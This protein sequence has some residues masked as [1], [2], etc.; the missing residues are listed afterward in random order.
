MIHTDTLIIGGGFSGAKVAQ[1]LAAAGINTLMLDRKDYFEVTYATLRNVTA[2]ELLPKSPRKRY[3]DFLAGKFIHSGVSEMNQHQ[4]ILENG[5]TITFRQAIIATGSRYETMPMVKSNNSL[6][7]EMRNQEQI[8]TRQDIQAAKDILILGG[9]VV[10]VEL[11]GEIAAAFPEK[12]VTLAHSQS[13][14]LD[15]FKPK[16]QKLAFKQL[17]ALGVKI[18]TNRLYRAEGDRY[19]DANTGHTITADLV[20]SAIGTQPNSEFLKPHLSAALNKQ[21]YVKVDAYFQVEGYDNLYSLGDIANT[22]SPKLG[23]VAGMQADLLVKN[24]LATKAGKKA[25]P[26]KP[27]TKM[28]ALVPTGPNTGLVQLPFGVT[29]AKFM[30]N[31]KQRD[32]FIEKTFDGLDAQPDDEGSFNAQKA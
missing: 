23:Y 1:K 6:V 25:Q 18:E 10:G 17:E 5:E 21:G 28:M 3:T 2:P 4:V 19:Q 30:V 13:T 15:T 8:K 9:G 12:T 29:K 32:L 24:I 26:Y 7:L 20:F 22:G 11:A 14:L 16:A 31:M 27:M